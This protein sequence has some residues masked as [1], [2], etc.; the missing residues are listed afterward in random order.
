MVRK[1]PTSARRSGDDYQDIWGLIFIA[2]WLQD[3]ER[4]KWLRYES[5]PLDEIGS[6][7]FLDDIVICCHD[8]R[9][10]LYQAKHKQDPTGDPWTWG[11][12]LEEKPGTRNPLPSLIRKWFTSY[13]NPELKGKIRTA[14]FLTNGLPD[15]DLSL[16]VQKGKVQLKNLQKRLP[17]VYAEIKRQLQDDTQIKNFFAEFEFKF[18]E[19]SVDALYA[20]AEKIY[21]EEVRATSEG[22]LRLFAQA[23]KEARASITRQITLAEVR[24]WCEFD[25]PRELNQSFEIPADFQ[26]FDDDTHEELLR[27][28]EDPSGGIQILVGRPGAGKSTYLS[29]LHADL[30]KKR[31][32]SIR[33]HYYLSTNEKTSIERL[34]ADRVFEALKA[35]CKKYPS[36]IG[37][38]RHKNSSKI[39]LKEFISEIAKASKQKKQSCVLIIDGLDHVLRYATPSELRRFLD[40]VCIPQ[41]GLWIIL[42]M[43]EVA[44]SELPLK[45]KE[46]C[47]RSKWIELPGLSRKSVTRLVLANKTGL[48]LPAET[49]LLEDICKRLFEITEGNPLHL[50]YCLKSL[51][52][53]CE[54]RI[55]E[56]KHCEMLTPFGGD[57]SEYYRALWETLPAFAKTI[58][59][60]IKLIDYPLKAK[61]LN[62]IVSELA[63]KPTEISEG[64]R[65]V[66]HLLR[67]ASRGVEI[68]HSSFEYFISEQAEWKEQRLAIAKCVIEWLERAS[69]EYLKWLLIPK[70]KLVTGDTGSLL[71]IDRKWLLQAMQYP[72]DAADIKDLLELASEVAMRDKK[73]ALALKL[74]LL[75]GYF[76]NS[77]E[78][79]ESASEMLWI[80]AFLLNE[81][82]D[83]PIILT[84]LTA[85]Q[86]YQFV[87]YLAQTED[88]K[89]LVSKCI[90]ILNERHQDARFIEKGEIG[91]GSVPGLPLN[92]V[93]LVALDSS[94]RVSDVLKYIRSFKSLKWHQDLITAYCN[95]LLKGHIA[96]KVHQLLQSGLSTEE[97]S[98]VLRQ[99]AVDDLCNN[100]RAFIKTIMRRRLSID[101][102]TQACLCLVGEQVKS[103]PQLRLSSQIPTEWPEHRSYQREEIS[104]MFCGLFMT[105]FVYGIAGRTDELNAWSDTLSI[106]WSHKIAK[107]LAFAGRA[108]ASSV[109]EQGK[110]SFE[111][112]LHEVSQVAA[113]KWP[114]DRPELELQHGMKL[115]F[116]KVIEFIRMCMIAK[117]GKVLLTQSD[118]VSLTSSAYFD[119]YSL[120][121]YLLSAE[122]ARIEIDAVEWLVSE[123]LE[124]WKRQ[125]TT[126]SERSERYAQLTRICRLH[127]CNS[128]A[129][130]L[131]SLTADNLVA[132]GYH[133]DMLWYEILKVIDACHKAGSSKAAAWIED[134]ATHIEYVCD[135]T[136]GDETDSIDDEMAEMLAYINP[137]AIQARYISSSKAEDFYNAE[138]SFEC[139]LQSY[140]FVS[141]FEQAVGK[142]AV[143]RS[144]RYELKKSFESKPGA[145]KALES[146]NSYFGTADNMKESQESKSSPYPNRDKLDVAS[147]APQDL[148]SKLA[149]FR[150][151]YEEHEFLKEWADHWLQGT[152]KKVALDKL[153]KYIER[154]GIVY[155]DADLLDRLYPL[156]IK[157][158]PEAAFEMVC[159]AQANGYGWSW[160]GMPLKKYAQPRWDFI[161]QH[162]PRRYW[163]FFKRS[164]TYS[165]RRVYGRASQVYFPIVRSI[166][167]L[168]EF[169]ELELCEQLIDTC[170][171]FGK[172]L[173]AN[174]ELPKAEWIEQTQTTSLDVLFQRLVESSP[175]VRERAATAIADLLVN[176]KLR[177]EVFE[178]LLSW[179]STQDLETLVAVGLLPLLRAASQA[180]STVAGLDLDRLAAAIKSSSVV[181]DEELRYLEVLTSKKIARRKSSPNGG[182]RLS[183]SGHPSEFFARN[184]K[185]YLGQSVWNAG[186]ELGPAFLTEWSAMSELLAIKTSA[187]RNI[188]SFVRH[189][190]EYGDQGVLGAMAVKLTDVYMTAFLRIVQSYH[191][192]RLMDRDFLLDYSLKTLPIDMSLWQVAPGR[193][194]EW[195]P[196]IE[197]AAKDESK[198]IVELNYQTGIEKL[199][200]RRE[201][202]TLLFMEGPLRPT[203]GFGGV[204][205]DCSI[206][207]TAFAYRSDGPDLPTASDLCEFLLHRPRWLNIPTRAKSPLA[208]LE[209]MPL[210]I[211]AGEE[212]V[213]FD[214]LEVT[215]LV[216]RL[217]DLTSGVWQW[218]RRYPPPV[219]IGPIAEPIEIR[220]AVDH[221]DYVSGGQTIATYRD[222]TE[223]LEERFKPEEAFPFGRY[224]E[225]PTEIIDK[226]LGARRL[227][228]GYVY[229][230]EH[231][232]KEKDWDKEVQTVQQDH[233]VGVSAIVI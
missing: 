1:N 217:H 93:R 74:A 97:K 42:G 45:V 164:I 149:T 65:A 52:N 103:W 194:P 114:D 148:E 208:I 69:Y 115:A 233:L 4:F 38:L 34:R 41:E 109:R 165:A 107:A 216:L 40:E 33:H 17:R 142:T 92:L 185:H 141:D 170:I 53:H 231:Q 211:L 206:T 230:V 132:Y 184:A 226:W 23:K 197:K 28:V 198:A 59:A 220:T 221:W 119:D 94:R 146:L 2:D 21:L 48:T 191:K 223:G 147:I 72:R 131:L 171:S 70:L 5:V 219:A 232:F 162:F 86:L 87:A 207:L 143:D 57:I 110:I 159:Y 224:L 222:W 11:Q 212:T 202:T 32:L 175:L 31:V 225:A 63:S 29:K 156:I 12:L 77:A 56:N 102:Y 178:K 128:S 203:T 130:V 25:T 180:P 138:Q 196:E 51:K 22:F 145:L 96:D 117:D 95:A 181:I 100:R 160:I 190:N 195:W 14:A 118:L 179:I 106:A 113:L 161:K 182:E 79:S 193:A 136:D 88:V 50:R 61:Q 3:P 169:G 75:K 189:R 47:P 186:K 49:R 154:D 200:G 163:E 62:E 83:I 16:C 120:I 111:P 6:N 20:Q 68:Y 172:T 187:V 121:Q 89:D 10:C 183:V 99:C 150:M 84:N 82:K 205:L 122:A 36:L 201:G 108:Y 7:F 58:A 105:G 174:L 67:F 46:L 155:A 188:M 98:A 176:S 125:I 157:S 104:E 151:P 137:A 116:R 44:E 60:A 54:E 153:C 37:R 80:D 133:K 90:P 127:R 139:V 26:Y 101:V 19:P 140:E 199:I 27:K 73:F 24:S 18:G 144:S 66:S 76:V 112:L 229:R 91:G 134:I 71:S 9:F 209:D 158:D 30:Q 167:F 13:H 173:T 192:K 15:A 213:E 177:S 168:L 55:I 152:E 124:T 85:E 214:D 227:R 123:Q 126:F 8:D 215:P 43:Q 78:D 39:D 64:L 166:Q 228:L 129:K 81:P 210:L 135:Y 218:F 35:E 204:A